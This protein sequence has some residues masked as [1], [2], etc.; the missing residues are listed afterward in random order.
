MNDIITIGSATRDVF[1]ASKQFQV[2][3]SSQIPTGVGECVPLGSKVDIDTVVHTTGGG[4]TNSACTFS[5]LGFK[6]SAITRI[7]DD[8]SG[9]DV[10]KD[11]LGYK[12]KTSL[13]KIINK[14]TTGY[15]VLLTTSDGERTALVHRGVSGE[16]KTQDIPLSK[17]SC[18]WLYMTSLGGN[19]VLAKTIIEHARKKNALVCFNPGK[20]ELQKG[21]SAFRSIL[22][23]LTVLNLNL[24]EAQLLAKT[25]TTN[26]KELCKIIAR[27]G[28]MLIITDGPKGAY[29]HLD[30]ITWF[31]RPQG[32]KAIS[33]TGAGDAFGSG[34]VAGLAKGMGIDEALKIGIF[35]AESVIQSYG[36]KIGIIKT[37]PTDALKKKI[38][39][40]LI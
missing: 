27:P 36:A 28:L 34:V 22:N 9:K 23:N 25:S 6:T 40:T 18:K 1:L 7:G 15:S 32:K 31:V 35:N 14:K 20:Q 24:E 39:V 11:L 38:K 19:L 29:A 26:I 10:L 21:L 5:A 4:G 33:R 8:D 2:I 17:L 37:W 12:V 13:V 30:G 16:F 3:K